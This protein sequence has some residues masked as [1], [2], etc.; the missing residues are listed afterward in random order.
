[1]KN[2]LKILPIIICFLLMAAHLSRANLNI[3]MAA[4]LILPLILLWKSRVSARIVQIVLI[5]FG[6]EW[7]RALIYYARVRIENGE[8]WLRLAIILIVVA[9]INFVTIF[10]YR[11]RYM[12]DRYNLR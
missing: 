9:I 5:L 1:M 12:I 10:V 7:I 4:S 6:L 11:S 3:L 2:F 8:D